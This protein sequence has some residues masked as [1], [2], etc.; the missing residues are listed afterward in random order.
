MIHTVILDWPAELISLNDRHH[1]MKRA[2]LTKAWRHHT[3]A[4]F[5]DL[6]RKHGTIERARIVVTYR[7]PTDRRRDV[8]NLQITTKAICDGIVDSGLLVDDDDLHLVGPDNRRERPNGP[9]RV[10]V[11]VYELAEVDAA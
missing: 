10:S 7:F 4:K 1:H 11:V 8:G 5:A 9:P 2:A 3:H 6:A